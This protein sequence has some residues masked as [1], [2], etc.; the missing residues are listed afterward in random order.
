MAVHDFNAQRLYCDIP[1]SDGA[2]IACTTDHANYL[3]NV[4]RLNVG[5]SILVFN[6]VDGEW[7]AEITAAKK[8]LCNLN[9]SEQVRAQEDGPDVE[10]LFAPL[11]RARLDYM[12]QKATELGVACLRPVFTQHTVADRVNIARM[13]S[14]VIE[15]A[16]QCGIL[17]LPIVNEPEKLSAVLENWDSSRRLIFADESAELSSPLEALAPVN[18]EPCAL[19][20]GPEGGFSSQERQLLLDRDFTVRISLGPRIMRADTAAVSALAL[21]NAVAGDWR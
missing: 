5:D 6:G 7:R 19:I 8:R 1:L 20:I 10:Y 21:I 14:N 9:V 12:V 3:V 2:D 13:R 15:A 16:E 17:R 11:K 4:L 18:G